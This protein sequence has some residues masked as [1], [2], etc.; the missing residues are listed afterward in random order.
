[1]SKFI[2]TQTRKMVGSFAGVGALI[3][4]IKGVIKIA[5]ID[6][7]VFFKQNKHLILQYHI[8]DNRL[9]SRLKN[10]KGFPKIKLL[11]Q[12]PG[13]TVKGFSNSQYIQPSDHNNV[14]IGSYFPE[15]MFC[16][17]CHRF[18]SIKYWWKKSVKLNTFVR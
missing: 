8:H 2:Q 11:I 12:L 9:L 1:M 4:D 16:N 6:Q 5:P 18:N 14:A 13:N 7:W 15:W 17:K 3:E 10:D